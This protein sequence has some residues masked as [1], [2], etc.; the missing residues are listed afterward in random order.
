MVHIRHIRE[1]MKDRG[2]HPRYIQNVWGVG[3]K[4]GETL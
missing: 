3:Y 1:K 4:L 2:E